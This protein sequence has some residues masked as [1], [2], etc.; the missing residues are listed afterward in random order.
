MATLQTAER[1]SR[2]ASD[3]FVFQRSILAYHEAAKRVS[4]DVLEI[5]TGSGYGIEVI[6][7][8]THRFITVDKFMAPLKEALPDNVECRQATVPP[9]PF[10]SESFD[11]II[12]FQ[13]IEHIEDDIAFVRELHRVLRPGGKVII[14]TPNAPMSLTRNPWHVREYRADELD[15]LFS[16]CFDEICIE[17][18]IGNEAVADYYE[19]NRKSVQRITRWDI[20]DLQHR[21]PRWMLQIPYDILNRI[22]RR[23]LLAAAPEATAAIRMKDYQLSPSTEKSFDLFLMATKR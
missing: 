14:S 22:N 17:G 23:K 20:L 13:V 16:N 6:A 5:G 18:V 11:Y 10:A 8:H 9:L 15:K 1:V 7:P 3:N 21:L 4:G 19:R 12:S 2:E